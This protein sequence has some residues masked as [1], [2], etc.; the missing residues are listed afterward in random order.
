MI[1]IGIILKYC[2]EFGKWEII[3]MQIFYIFCQSHLNW[4]T[5]A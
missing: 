5:Y 3:E 4:M 2:M 1:N